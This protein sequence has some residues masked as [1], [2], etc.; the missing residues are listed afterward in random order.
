MRCW[1]AKAFESD[2]G[3]GVLEYIRNYI[4]KNRRLNLKGLPEQLDLDKLSG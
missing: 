2:E 3:L 4:P 1:D